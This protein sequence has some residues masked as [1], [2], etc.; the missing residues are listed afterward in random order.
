MM[1]R[2]V[3]L[4]DYS[5]SWKDHF[6]PLTVGR[7]LRIASPWHEVVDDG[8]LVIRI[9]P[10]QAFG[11]GQHPTTRGCLLE[12]ERALARRGAA[13]GLDLGCGSGVLAFAMRGLGVKHVVAVDNDPAARAATAAG[14]ALNGYDDIR[15]G[16]DVKR[17]RRRFELIVAN[18]FSRVLVDLAP[19][20]VGL[21]A[22]GGR[23]IVSGLLARQEDEVRR[24]LAR[25]G[26][27]IEQRRAISGWVTLSAAKAGRPPS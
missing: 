3:T 20:L 16:A 6:R 19:T 12:I 7:S 27:R 4:P 17:L 1:L 24:A 5:T 11:T 15:I 18:L 25:C 22:P 26:L 9:D 2:R 10:G 13:S 14:S 23:L 8:R 21:L